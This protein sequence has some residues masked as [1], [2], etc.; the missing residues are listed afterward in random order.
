M[1]ECILTCPVYQ[2]RAN[3]LQAEFEENRRAI[4]LAPQVRGPRITACPPGQH[5]SAGW[6]LTVQN[7][8]VQALAQA[9]AAA[10]RD[11]EEAGDSSDDRSGSE[12]S[13]AHHFEVEGA[14]SEQNLSDGSPDLQ[15]REIEGARADAMVE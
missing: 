8:E 4:L 6:T 14:Q 11:V 12:R 13:D 2:A 7:W 1:R 15:E 3:P 9:Q 5:A 10:A